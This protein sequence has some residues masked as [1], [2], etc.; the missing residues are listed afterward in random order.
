M[1]VQG[2]EVPLVTLVA[3][4]ATVRDA[5]VGTVVFCTANNKNGS[6]GILRIN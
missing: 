6:I 1:G 2:E 3:A 4:T 5:K